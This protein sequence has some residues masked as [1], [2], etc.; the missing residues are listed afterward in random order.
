[1]EQRKSNQ[2]SMVGFG[3]LLLI[4]LLI[5]GL[6]SL[7]NFITNYQWFKLNSYIQTFLVKVKTE[8]FIIVPLTLLIAIGLFFYLKQLK[9]QYYHAAHI[10]YNAK[11][12]KNIHKAMM[13]FTSLFGF[14]ISLIIS[15]NIW[16]KLRLFLS[17][18]VFNIKDPIFNKD[19]GFYVFKLPLYEQVLASLIMIMF[20]LVFVTI[21]FFVI[22]MTIRHA[23]EN[24]T[25]DIHYINPQQRITEVLK[26]E[27]TKAAVKRIAYL[28]MV[29][30]L[31]FSFRYY[32]KSYELMYSTRGVA[33]GA[34]YTDIHVTLILYRVLSIATLISS[35]IFAFS[36]LKSKTKLAISVPI[37]LISIGIL[38]ST[39]ALVV[40]QL[41]VEPDEISKERE[42]LEYNI[43]Y[44]QQAFGLK[45]VK[46]E[47][48]LLE[49][50]LTWQD[51][52]E[53]NNTIK[54]IRINDARPLQQTYN[55]IQA[56][57]L[58]YSFFGLDL[59]RYII[60]GEYRQVFISARELNQENLSEQAKT[61]ITNI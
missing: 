28:G 9:R 38:G 52:L 29:T 14:F 37:A 1:M 40:Q 8:V 17:H 4:G 56:I 18:E 59:D 44:T 34:S 12:D 3:V 31:L 20:L 41:I 45:E 54:N 33:Y 36:L 57:R 48:F 51:I 6:K 27:V 2:W 16:I 42:Y 19:I 58:Y 60:D 23:A 11:A 26:N 32:L 21:I 5:S 43:E 55:Q 39:I 25:A 22:I 35:F 53:N 46:E 30:L 50:T 15:N 61:W 24:K 49:Q 10:F 13:A 47:D 7:T